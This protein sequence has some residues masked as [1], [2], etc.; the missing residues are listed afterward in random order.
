MFQVGSGTS[1]RRLARQVAHTSETSVIPSHFLAVESPQ[2]CV[3][4]VGTELVPR[5]AGAG[6]LPRLR[7]LK[8]L[9]DR[10][11]AAP[12]RRQHRS[13]VT[14]ASSGLAK[15]RETEPVY[16]NVLCLE[17][18]QLPWPTFVRESRLAP[19]VPGG[20]LR[21]CNLPIEQAFAIIE[22]MWFVT[23]GKWVAAVVA[24]QASGPMIHGKS[25]AFPPPSQVSPLATHSGGR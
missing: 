12:P 7:F 11:P 25:T 2:S 9:S 3:K 14:P 19:L 8:S 20:R 22:S 4:P 15:P 1:L 13:V 17:S 6:R 16:Q 23:V 24:D 18:S 10:Q 5:Q 21:Q